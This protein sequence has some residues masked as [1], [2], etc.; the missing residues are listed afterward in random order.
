MGAGRPT[1]RVVRMSSATLVGRA[2]LGVAILEMEVEVAVE[3]CSRGEWIWRWGGRM[4]WRPTLRGW[5]W[6][7]GGRIRW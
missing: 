3:D 1:D 7:C 6:W 4:W 2:G 5:I